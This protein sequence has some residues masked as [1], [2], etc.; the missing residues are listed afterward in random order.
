MSRRPGPRWCFGGRPGLPSPPTGQG[1]PI[2]S[3]HYLAAVAA[4]VCLQFQAIHTTSDWDTKGHGV[5]MSL[6]DSFS[7][8]FVHIQPRGIT[9]G[10]YWGVIVH[11]LG[12]GI[13]IHCGEELGFGGG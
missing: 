6:A 13:S 5:G 4:A 10:G 1:P 11:V 9:G 2:P 3:F 8:Q 12:G 7:P